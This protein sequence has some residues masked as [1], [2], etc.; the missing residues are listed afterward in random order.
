LEKETARRPK[1]R[2]GGGGRG[3]LGGAERNGLK[4]EGDWGQ[5]EGEQRDERDARARKLR[6]ETKWGVE[7]A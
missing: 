6:E 3:T 7:S 1:E 5:R 4:R 2:K